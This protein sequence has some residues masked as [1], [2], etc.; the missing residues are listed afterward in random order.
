MGHSGSSLRD[1][2]RTIRPSSRPRTSKPSICSSS[3]HS[4]NSLNHTAPPPMSLARKLARLLHRVGSGGECI[5]TFD[6]EK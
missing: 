5:T 6:Q 2:R 3:I 4:P 1:K